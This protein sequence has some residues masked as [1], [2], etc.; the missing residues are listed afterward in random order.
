MK[1]TPGCAFTFVLTCL[2]AQ[3]EFGHVQGALRA[4]KEKNSEAA[5]GEEANRRHLAHH[6]GNHAA[7]PPPPPQGQGDRHH[8]SG[9]DGGQPFERLLTMLE[10]PHHFISL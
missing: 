10:L 7:A 4:N 8:M 1:F 6:G 9:G 3:S 5:N 2:V